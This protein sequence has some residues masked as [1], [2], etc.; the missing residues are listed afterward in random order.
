MQSYPW[1]G[2][3]RE[4][5]NRVR[6]AMVMAEGGYITARDLQLAEPVSEGAPGVTIE[7]ARREGERAAIERALARSGQRVGPAA[8]ELGISRVTLYR[9]M[10]RH[11][12]H[13]ARARAQWSR[14]ALVKGGRE[15]P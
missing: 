6:E 8:D 1:P 12:L 14:L 10:L 3:V 13:E 9:L 5:I 7:L 11:G 15:E 2:N 4:L